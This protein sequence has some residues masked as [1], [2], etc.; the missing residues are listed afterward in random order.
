MR[1]VLKN[2]VGWSLQSL[3]PEISDGSFPTDRINLH[4]CPLLNKDGDARSINLSLCEAVDDIEMAQ[5]F[6]A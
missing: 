1:H 2:D 4:N 6:D 5:V 3:V